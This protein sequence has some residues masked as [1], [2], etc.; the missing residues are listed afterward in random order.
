[1]PKNEIDYSNTIIY[2]IIC[3]DEK[4]SD[5]YVGHTTNFVKRKCLHKNSCNNLNN[6]L[7]IYNIIRENGGW[8]NWDMIEIAR[9]NCN[10]N[11]EARIKEQEHYD[12]LKATLNSCPPYVDKSKFCCT[13]CNL[14]CNSQKEYIKHINCELH[15]KKIECSKINTDNNNLYLCEN[16]NYTCSKKHHLNQHFLTQSHKKRIVNNVSNSINN[17]SNSINNT[18]NAIN[19]ICSKCNKSYKE[20]SGL[21]KHKKRC[22]QEV[23]NGNI[24]LTDT[25]VILQL[26]KQNDDFKELLLEQSKTILHQNNKLFEICK[27]VTSNT[28]INSNNTNSNNKSFNL[29]FFLNETCKDAMN[30]MDF[31]ESIKLQLSDVEKVGEL[32]YVDGISNIIVKNLNA[33]EIEKR[34]VHCT[35]KKREVLYIKHENKWEKDDDDKN[36]IRKAIKKVACKNQRLL[37]KFKE[38]HPDCIK[39]ASK[40]SDQYNKMIIE[41][42][43][44]SGDNDLEK[45]NKIIRNIS[46]A[47]I[48]SKNEEIL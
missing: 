22:I 35:D 20:R 25:N 31:V 4:I 27:N 17:V 11:R 30:I 26:I 8:D 29:Q 48:I 7:K 6:K 42:M 37:P 45:E 43:G 41:S 1:M 18:E 9:Y 32:G 5:V 2:K 40:F 34:P 33:L 23:S 21:W 24:D 39:A 19:F 47:T 10:D 16:C 14:H 13:T 15:T 3:K 12:L 28:T 36:K 38:A 44:G 46:K